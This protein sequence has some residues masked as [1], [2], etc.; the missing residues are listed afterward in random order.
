M[1]TP[2]QKEADK[3]VTANGKDGRC[4]FTFETGK[5]TCTQQDFV[6]QE[7]HF[8]VDNRT[9][10]Q[11]AEDDKLQAIRD[12]QKRRDDL[13]KAKT[14]KLAGGIVGGRICAAIILGVVIC[15]CKAKPKTRV[16]DPET[17]ARAVEV[18]VQ[19][20]RDSLL[21]RPPPRYVSR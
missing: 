8:C 18:E 17:L 5:Y 16:P 12:E 4:L 21:E 20:V 6:C 1:R 9:P 3:Q 7:E 15:C 2:E 11:K 19:K 13:E 14:G 10:E